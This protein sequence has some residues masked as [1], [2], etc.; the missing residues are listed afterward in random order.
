VGTLGRLRVSQEGDHLAID[1]L[2]GPPPLLPP[3]FRFAFEPGAT[4][5]RY[6]VTPVG[7]GQR[8]RE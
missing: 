1:Y 8:Q 2:D 6:V 4:H 7:V 5:A 3:S